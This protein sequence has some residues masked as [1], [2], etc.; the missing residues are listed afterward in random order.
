MLNATSLVGHPPSSSMDL[1]I[2]KQNSFVAAE[3]CRW[4][5]GHLAHHGSQCA[6][7]SY[8]GED[9]KRLQELSQISLVIP[10]LFPFDSPARDPIFSKTTQ[11][12][13]LSWRYEPQ[14]HKVL[15]R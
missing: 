3:A 1:S 13:Y 12:S 11:S 2:S 14:Q 15:K 4:L 9:V 10:S 7:W 5:D 6:D 8:R